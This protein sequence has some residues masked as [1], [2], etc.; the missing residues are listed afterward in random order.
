MSSKKQKQKKEVALIRHWRVLNPP[1]FSPP[2]QLHRIFAP[3]PSPP[4]PSPLP[5]PTRKSMFDGSAVLW[6]TC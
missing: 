5:L 2:L 3:P 4:P 1:P 6:A